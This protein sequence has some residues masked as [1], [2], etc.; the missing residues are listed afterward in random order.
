[1]ESIKIFLVLSSFYTDIK[2]DNL[3]CYTFQYYSIL[4]LFLTS[5]FFTQFGYSFLVICFIFG[6]LPLLDYYIVH[7]NKNP[8]KEEQKKLKNDFRYKVPIYITIIFDWILLIYSIYLIN[9]SE[10]GLLFKLGIFLSVSLMQGTSINLSH[11]INHKLSKWKRIFGTFNLSKNLYM[12]FLIEHNEGHHK[13]VSTP[14]DP[15]SSQKNESL[16]QFL[17]RTIIGGFFS[18]WEI[19]KRLCNQKYGKSF[20]IY[21]R[22]IYFTA[23]YIMIPL[24]IFLIFNFKV[25]LT[26]F[27]IAFMSVILLETINYIEHYGLKRNKLE[28]GT[29]EN[30]TIKHS[31][32]A[33]HRVS[34]YLLFKLQRHSDHHENALKPYQVLC[35]YDESPTLPTGYA[36]CLL[37]AFYPKIWFKIMNPLV[38]VYSK[39]EMPS[40]QLNQK[41]Q[42]YMLSY[43]WTIN[44]ILLAINV[45]Q[46]MIEKIM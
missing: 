45:V 29:Y 16:Y 3:I 23:S 27:F 25:M 21:N 8:T 10:R 33:P 17:P 6:S 15:A 2:K 7:D 22:M 9:Y 38:D 4:L 37:L 42:E 12:H 35:S 24:T 46:F 18:A 40:K 13:N 41:L 26:H 30:V 43:I 34:N 28:D 39:G 36:G 44:Y 5:F 31:W 1:M 32:N 20:S 11:E 19:E 14:I